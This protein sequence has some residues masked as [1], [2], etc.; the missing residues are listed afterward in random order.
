MVRKVASVTVLDS[1][2]RQLRHGRR[3]GIGGA[4]M[5][6]LLVGFAHTQPRQVH[7]MPYGASPGVS[8]P[9]GGGGRLI[10][11]GALVAIVIVRCG[12]TWVFSGRWYGVQEKE[13]SV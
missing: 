2:G 13:L 12:L 7:L 4:P 1:N 8:S 11:V 6:T 5:Y 3:D 9:D 10:R